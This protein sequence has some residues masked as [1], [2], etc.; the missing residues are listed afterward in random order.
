MESDSYAIKCAILLIW[1]SEKFS[2]YVFHFYIFFWKK[3]VAE[4]SNFYVFL[5][6]II[7]SR[8]SHLTL[9][10]AMYTPAIIEITKSLTPT[11]LSDGKVSIHKYFFGSDLVI[12]I[13][14][15]VYI[16]WASVKCDLREKII[17]IKKT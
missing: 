17:W 8:K 16:A 7:F 11:Y 2:E 6:Q 13:I 4:P 3:N 9:A 5:I 10:H 14:A 15:G 12:S 1:L